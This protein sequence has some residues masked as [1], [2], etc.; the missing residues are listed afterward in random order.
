[1]AQIQ[2]IQ[3]GTHYRRPPATKA[4]CVCSVCPSRVPWN[5]YER[6]QAHQKLEESNADTCV[7]LLSVY[8]VL[9]N[10]ILLT[11]PKRFSADAVKLP[12]RL[13]SRFP[14]GAHAVSNSCICCF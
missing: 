11:T 5:Y 4:S 2:K 3:K 10:H 1:M 9:Q 8:E 13:L 12:N 6:L 14:P 7:I